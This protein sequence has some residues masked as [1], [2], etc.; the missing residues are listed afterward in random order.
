MLATIDPARQERGYA[1]SAYY[2]PVRSRPNLHVITEATVTKVLLD[3]L[4]GEWVAT[5]VRVRHKGEEMDITAAREVILSAGSI[6]SPQILE[7]S[8]IGRRDILEA[9]GVE[10]HVH[11]ANV[12]ENLQDHISMPVPIAS[13]E[14]A[15][16]SQ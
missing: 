16:F 3:S 1:A 6:Q 4:D 10:V 11:N 13:L 9:A 5:A 2:L 15:D 12:G 8:G 7:L 14:R